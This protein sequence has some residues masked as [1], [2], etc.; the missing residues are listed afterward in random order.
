MKIAIVHNRDRSG[1]INNFGAPCPEVYGAKTIQMVADALS[2]CG[3]EVGVFE[4][5]KTLLSKIERFLPSGVEGEP[6]GMVFNMAYGIQGE[7]RYVHV[8]AMLEMAGVPYTGSGP[9]GHALALD[10]VTA[11]DLFRQA[12]VPTPNYRA[13]HK[14]DGAANGLR[15]PLVVKPRHESTS[16]G[17]RLA[18]SSR[19]LEEAIEVVVSQYRQ[20]ALVEEYVEGREICVGLL[21]NADMEFLPLVE[22]DFSGRE[23]RMVTCDDKYHRAADLRKLCPA[24]VP[25]RL[26]ARLREISLAAFRACHCKDFARVDLRI[27]AAGAPYVLEIN[28]MASLGAGGSYVLAATAAGY[29][30][31]SLVNRILDIAHE[32]YF[33]VPAPRAEVEREPALMR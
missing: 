23:I 32:R 20:D 15:F 28:S 3:H 17:L 24:D 12:G 25:A 31:S 21:G 16:F 1:V 11:K 4:G 2:E 22:Q 6:G 30:F 10:K 5:D 13:T 9:F 14:A 27:D 33:G 7:C 19:E 26:A 8:P 18:H 29:T